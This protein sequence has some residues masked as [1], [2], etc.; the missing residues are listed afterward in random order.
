MATQQEDRYPSVK[1]FQEAI[2]T[3]QAHSESL[4]LTA[5][6]NLNLQNARESGDY[7]L[8]GVVSSGPFNAPGLVPVWAGELTSEGKTLQVR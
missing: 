7:Q 1:E 5:H 6:A 2:R 8:F 4:V 3:Y